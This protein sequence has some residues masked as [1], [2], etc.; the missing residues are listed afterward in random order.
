VEHSGANKRYYLA[1]LNHI[2]RNLEYDISVTISPLG[3]F[4]ENGPPEGTDVLSYQT[5]PDQ[6][7]S[8]KFNKR[9]IN[10]ADHQFLAFTGKK[11]I[12]DSHDCGDKDAFER[13]A[14]SKDLP[15]VKCFP[16]KWFLSNYNVILLSTVSAMPGVVADSYIRTIPISC[17]FGKKKDGFYGHRIREEVTRY[18]EES[19]SHLTDFN[20]VPD[21][22]QYLKELGWTRIVIGAPGWGRY[23][24]SHWG[25]MKY[26]ALLFCYHAL[27]EIKLYP[28][29]DL[30]D[31]D[32]FIS[33]NMF[34][35]KT[36]LERVIFD[37]GEFERIRNN[38]R[39]KF[40]DGLNIKKSAL[41]F[42]EYLKG[43]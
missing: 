42:V 25:A 28:H 43:V 40:N 39:K 27:N 10:K 36:K 7:N 37:E 20:W 30:S 21:R 8:G 5:F 24:G 31:G 22:I 41:Q 16:S 18:L 1:V 33:Y 4:I 6:H 12:V 14:I 35:F 15:R 26:G 2:R 11:I 29:V 34:N 17:K 13:F 23:N 3:K 32:D 9:I 19:F 38:G